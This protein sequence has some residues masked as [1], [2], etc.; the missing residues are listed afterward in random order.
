MKIEVNLNKKV[1]LSVIAGFL[2]F[3]G[4]LGAIA[5]NSSPANP[6][7]LGHSLSEIDGFPICSS[8]YVLT[9]TASGLSC[10]SAGSGG[11]GSVAC[12]PSLERSS[13]VAGTA[14][15]NT[16]TSA[17]MVSASFMSNVNGLTIITGYAS[18]DATFDG[19]EIVADDSGSGSGARESISFLVL[20][21]QYYK[22]DGTGITYA[23]VWKL[24]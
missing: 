2:I 4:V 18:S 14:Y 24:C 8:G 3:A 7:V 22:V 23:R 1:A 17:L 5:Y 19:N 12:T 6:A 21:G 20:P 10:V 13:L 11:G 9:S 15:Q 16:G